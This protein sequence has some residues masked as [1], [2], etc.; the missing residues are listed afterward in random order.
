M[1]P[2]VGDCCDSYDTASFKQSFGIVL[3]WTEPP[4]WSCRSRAFPTWRD[5]TGASERT[6]V[7]ASRPVGDESSPILDSLVLAFRTPHDCS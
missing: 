2:F 6:K 3:F 4:W 7:R 1:T 5:S